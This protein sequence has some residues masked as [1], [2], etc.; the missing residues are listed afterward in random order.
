MKKLVENLKF[1]EEKVSER[2]AFLGVYGALAAFAF[3]LFLPWA[4]APAGVLARDGGSSSGWSELAFLSLLPFAGLILSVAS[5]R[6]PIKPATLLICIAASFCLLA[7]NNVLDR[8][9]WD[10]PFQ[11]SIDSDAFITHAN[12]GSALGAGFWLGLLALVA[13]SVFGLA[14]SLHKTPTLATV[15]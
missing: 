9:H 1:I 6:R 7:F 3:S 2:S 11:A 8:S 12:F 13:M 14:W 15:G 10:R 4:S 5:V